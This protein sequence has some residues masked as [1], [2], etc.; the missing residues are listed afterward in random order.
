M[1]G[2]ENVEFSF[3]IWMC[4]GELM[5]APCSRVHHIFRFGGHPYKV[6][7]PSTMKNRLST[8]SVWMDEYAAITHKLI[9]EPDWHSAGDVSERLALRKQLNCHNF[10]WYLKN[11]NPESMIIDYNDVE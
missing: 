8:A 3:R 7:I 1:W 10:D 11:V 2:Q 5:C 4:G 9:G 6:D